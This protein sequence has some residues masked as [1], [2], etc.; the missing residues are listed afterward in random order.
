M[1]NRNKQIFIYLSCFIP[2]I[3]LISETFL[4]IFTTVAGINLPNRNKYEIDP[5]KNFD[6]NTG[7]YIY[8]PSKKDLQNKNSFINRHG[9]IRTYR[10]TNKNSIK[11]VKGIAILGNSV[12]LG[13][14]ATHQGMFEK[15]FVNLLEKELIKKDQMIDIVNLSH[16]G[17]NSWQENVQ[18][19]K[20]LNSNNNFNDLPNI[21]LV[22]SI[23]GIQDL[24]GFINF[25]DRYISAW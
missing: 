4:A 5:S 24:W 21:K 17:Y 2:L 8:K 25:L 6:L 20:Y 7:S 1:A 10:S 14:P 16:H 22:A 23:G 11:N 15:S 19:V 18:L 9:L 3:I 13:Y 12:A